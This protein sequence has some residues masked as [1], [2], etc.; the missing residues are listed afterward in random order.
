VR[1]CASRALRKF[2]RIGACS[3][4]CSP[5]VSRF[6]GKCGELD[7]DASEQVINVG[8]LLFYVVLRI[9]D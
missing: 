9:S 4:R 2:C 5:I 6:H 8:D 3:F 1:V 7:I